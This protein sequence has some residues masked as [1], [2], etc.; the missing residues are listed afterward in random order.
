MNIVK[1]H[2]QREKMD[3]KSSSYDT[4]VEQIGA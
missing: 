4:N 2:T 3:D 1:Q